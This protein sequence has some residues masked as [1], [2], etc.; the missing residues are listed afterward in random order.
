MIQDLT[1]LA[2]QKQL[3]IQSNLQPV[4]INGVRLELHRVLTNLLGIAL[5]FTDE[6]A[7]TV[8]LTQDDSGVTLTIEDTGSGIYD[9]ELSHLFSRFR[10]GPHTRQGSGLG[11]YLSQQIVQAHN[12]TVSVASTVG[13]GSTFTV[14]LPTHL[15]Q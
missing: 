7:I 6:G 5:K 1:P 9:E 2:D 12:G 11:L 14:W 8:G 3:V 15:P 10:Q 13:K 4:H